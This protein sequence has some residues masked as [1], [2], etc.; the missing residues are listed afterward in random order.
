MK[1]NLKFACLVAVLLGTACSDGPTAYVAKK[2][3]V[4]SSC[5]TNIH[6]TQMAADRLIMDMTGQCDFKAIG[7]MDI[8]IHQECLFAGT[9]SN[10]TTHVASNGDQLKSTWFSAVGQNSFDGTNAV[11]E[12]VE[13]YVGGTGRFANATGSSAVKGTAKVDAASGGFTG[14]YTALGTI[15]F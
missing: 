7:K 5:T 6:T 2:Q 13:T 1:H 12:G 3:T 4:E 15:T 14:K 11:F 10:T 8:V 9:C